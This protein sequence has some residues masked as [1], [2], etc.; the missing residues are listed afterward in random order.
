MR[1]LLLSLSFWMML[2][3]A[4]RAQ[5][6]QPGWPQVPFETTF[7]LQSNPKLGFGLKDYL[8]FALPTNAGGALK[9]KV[10]PGL[11]NPKYVSFESVGSPGLF[12][13]HQECQMKL[14]PE[15]GHDGYFL[16]DAT[17]IPVMSRKTP[18]GWMF[19]AL[20]PYWLW[21]SVTRDN[22]IFVAPNPRFEDSTF[23]LSAAQ[24]APS[25]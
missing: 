9:F 14:N 1:H 12:L 22:A 25:H 23:V 15:E 21:I 13:R 6:A 2:A 7:T 4:A 24:S 3:L 17:F 5:S 19:R 16:N 11:A 18:G 10:V 8:L 20:F